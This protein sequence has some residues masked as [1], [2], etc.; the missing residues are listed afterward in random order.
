VPSVLFCTEDWS[1]LPDQRSRS[2]RF[3][4]RTFRGF[5]ESARSPHEKLHDPSGKEKPN[6][7]GSMQSEKDSKSLPLKKR[8]IPSLSKR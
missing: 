8:D 3:P 5:Q 6:G 4:N 7:N 1:I 2:R